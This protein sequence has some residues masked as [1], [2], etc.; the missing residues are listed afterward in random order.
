MIIIP[1]LLAPAYLHLLPPGTPP[2]NDFELFLE[3]LA[4][5]MGMIKRG[6]IVDTSRA[7][8]FFVQWWRDE[9]GLLAASTSLPVDA[10][11]ALIQGWGFDFQWNV[12]P[13]NTLS[14]QES[15]LMI[16]EKMEQCIDEYMETTDRE[17][18]EE[19]NVSQTNRRK[20]MILEEK[21]KRKRKLGKH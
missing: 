20:Q 14:G 2:T 1:V 4:Q 16:Q 12:R 11:S 8:V 15:A 7:A 13:Q 17:E 5:R 6:A 21:A 10:P 3:L 19:N 18:R 9:G